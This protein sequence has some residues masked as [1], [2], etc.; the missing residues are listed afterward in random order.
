MDRLAADSRTIGINRDCIVRSNA[1]GRA[2]P[3]R[4]FNYPRS[5]ARALVREPREQ[6]PPRT[7]SPSLE[8][9]GISEFFRRLVNQD[10]FLSSARTSVLIKSPLT[11]L[12][13]ENSLQGMGYDNDARRS[14]APRKFVR[15]ARQVIYACF[16]FS[17]RRMAKN[18]SQSDPRLNDRH[19]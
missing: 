14:T 4:R 10:T 11:K 8:L 17:N 9:L 2:E 18:D 1:E 6:Q 16:C 12:I 13:S 5:F 3:V 7:I 19:S 15:K